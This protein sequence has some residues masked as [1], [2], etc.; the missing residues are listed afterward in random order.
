MKTVL[1]RADTRGLANHGWLKS[2]HTFSF[3]GYFDPDRMHFGMLRVL[4]DDTVQGGM[5]FDTHPHKNMEIISI[6]LEGALEHRDSMGNMF[7]IR[8]NDI[9]VMSAGTGVYHSEYNHIKDA[10]TH[11]LQIWIL[12]REQD[13]KPRYDQKTVLPREKKNMLK[14]ILSPYPENNGLWIHQ[15]AWFYMGTLDAGYQETYPV[16]KPGNGVY[17][18]VIEGI[19]LVSGHV[20]QKRDGLGVSD[21]DLVL[22]RSLEDATEILVMDVPM[23]P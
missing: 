10:L 19:M 22:F 16:S 6:P 4:N 20:L 18:F 14:L 9:Q 12:P 5:G 15:D 8:K 13:V 3:A 11:F 21:T 23:K 1:H 7:V 17:F 2:R